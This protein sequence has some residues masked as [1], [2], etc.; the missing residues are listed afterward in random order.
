M[1]LLNF[2][3]HNLDFR[4]PE[5]EASLKTLQ[6][7]KKMLLTSTFSLTKF[8]TLSYTQIRSFTPRFK[9]SL[10]NAFN[11][12]QSKSLSFGEGETCDLLESYTEPNLY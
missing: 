11:W 6:E 4:Q 2:L 9:S 5:R 3:I 1:P 10:Q 12:V 7:K 8:S